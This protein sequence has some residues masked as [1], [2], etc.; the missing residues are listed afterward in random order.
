MEDTVNTRIKGSDAAGIATNKGE[1]WHV[2]S[3]PSQQ[4]TASLFR[5]GI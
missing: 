4:G 5:V 3:Q 2:Y 1:C